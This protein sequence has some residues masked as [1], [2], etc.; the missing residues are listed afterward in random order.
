MCH[1][2]SPFQLSHLQIKMFL[3][4]RYL[5]NQFIFGLYVNS[6][7]VIKEANGSLKNNYIPA[8]HNFSTTF[9]VKASNEIMQ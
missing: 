8:G 6:V 1:D 9:S 3:S 5:L 4:Q 7:L 2:I